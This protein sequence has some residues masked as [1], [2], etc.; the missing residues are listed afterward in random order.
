MGTKKPR[1]LTTSGFFG[2]AS[3]LDA[4][5]GCGGG[6]CKE[7]SDGIAKPQASVSHGLRVIASRPSIH[8]VATRTRSTCFVAP[9]SVDFVHPKQHS[10]VLDSSPNE[11]RSS[12]Y[13]PKERGASPFASKTK[14]QP[15]RDCFSFWLREWDLNLTTFGL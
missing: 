12:F 9:C 4:Q 2:L 11:H 15:T 13:N 5:Y 3:I 6:I 7:Q 10:V 8:I 1:S 14:K